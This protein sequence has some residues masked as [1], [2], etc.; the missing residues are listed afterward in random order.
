MPA[1]AADCAVRAQGQGDAVPAALPRPHLQPQHPQHIRHARTHHPGAPASL[2]ALCLAFTRALCNRCSKHLL[3]DRLSPSWPRGQTCTATPNQHTQTSAAR[4]QYVRRFLDTR[5]FLEVETPMMNMIPGGA[6]AAPFVTHHNDLG[7]DLYMRVAPELY[8]KMLVV[9][10]L[11]R[12]YEIG[13]QFRNEGIDMT[14]N[15]EFTTCEF[16][17]VRTLP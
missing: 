14:H 6:T 17:Q 15:P 10:G 11:D 8:L 7:M 3:P 5:G 16:Y 9:G 13:R 1:H 4:V 2:N 12:V